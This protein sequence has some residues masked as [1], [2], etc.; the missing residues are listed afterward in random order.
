L[1]SKQ[2]ILD[3]LY[4]LQ[5]FGIKPGLERT[6]KI[7]SDFG[8]PQDSFTSIH[9][10]G[11]NG[12]GFTCSAIASILMDAGYKVGLY[13]SPHLK[14]FNERIIINGKMISDDDIITLAERL[15]PYSE[16]INATFFE[17]T[18]A[19][20]FIY[21]AQQNIDI[22]VIETGMGGRFDSTNVLYPLLSIITDIGLEHQEYLGN[23]L[24]QIAFEK[25]GIIKKKTPC[26][27]SSIQEQILPVF[28]SKAKEMSAPM[29]YADD[30]SQIR[31]ISNNNDL[32]TNVDIR[33]DDYQIENLKIPVAGYHQIRN[34][35]LALSGIRIINDKYHITNEN[36][37][38]GLKNI[39]KN[40][41]Y[42]CRIELMNIDPLIIIDTAHNPQAINALVDTLKTHGHFEPKWDILYAAMN[43]KNVKNILE[44]LKPLCRSITLTEPRTNRAMQTEKMARIAEWLAYNSI[45]QEKDAE[46][47]YSMLIERGNNIF[48]CGSFFL[49]GEI[50]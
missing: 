20:A 38:G 10:A 15:I 29:H 16:T 1:H 18:T 22:A 30:I 39:R 31:I 49:A 9:I 25:A 48:V 35:G 33:L 11:T 14:E 19:M 13:T 41:N 46:K 12:K 17:I 42:R 44:S 7:L 5:R 24:E 4:S 28:Q 26:L 2:E 36:I 50:I 45:Y 40:T 3:K 8:D 27:V 47:A 32:T 21:L 43:D 23:T 6:Y 37:A 34:L